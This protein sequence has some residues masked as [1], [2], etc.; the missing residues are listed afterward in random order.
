M[1]TKTIK[2]NDFN[3]TERKE[4]CHFHLSKTELL[5]IAMELPEGLTDNIAAKP[6]RTAV[7]AGSLILRALGAKG[8]TQFYKTLILK[9]YGVKSLDGRR[10][11]K[12]E[13]LSA[14][15]SQTPMFDEL[16]YEIMT[17]D[18][19]ATEFVNN[20]IPESVLKDIS[21]NA[22]TAGA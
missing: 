7:E 1:F 8:V 10:F 15:F 5:E 13:Q 2:Y 18:D 14:E 19:K 12:S 3:G 16:Y 22:L 9:S 20:L 4:E 11:E 21:P 17:N 6:E